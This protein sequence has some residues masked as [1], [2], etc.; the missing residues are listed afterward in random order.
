MR[1]IFD[2]N[3]GFIRFILDGSDC[4]ELFIELLKVSTSWNIVR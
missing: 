1:I 4:G 3:D 2:M